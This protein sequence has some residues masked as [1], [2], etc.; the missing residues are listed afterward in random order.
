MRYR[1]ESKSLNG[2]APFLLTEVFLGEWGVTNRIEKGCTAI[3][4]AV[5]TV[6]LPVFGT[7]AGDIVGEGAGVCLG[8]GASI[9][10]AL[11]EDYLEDILIRQEDETG[12]SR[13]DRSKQF[14]YD[15]IWRP[16]LTSD[17]QDYGEDE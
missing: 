10:L 12:Q 9:L 3:G 14:Q 17:E 15:F 4:E 5:G 16:L 7:V 6:E 11:N 13:V 8:A 2:S 1:T